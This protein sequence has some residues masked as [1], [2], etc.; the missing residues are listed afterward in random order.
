MTKPGRR[1][2]T[3]I[4]VGVVIAGVATW[5]L[6]PL[7]ESDALRPSASVSTVADGYLAA[8]VRK[9]CVVTRALTTTNTWSWCTDPALVSYSHVG[10]PYTVSVTSAGRA[11][12]CV[13]FTMHTSGSGDGTM[14]T[15]EQ[16]WAL[17]FVHTWAGW[18]LWDQGQG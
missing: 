16:P 3:L 8:A 14:P 15:G 5:Q 13:P 6:A 7:M 11:E 4:G 18:R 1:G 2:W 9:E 17:C 10:K 12:E